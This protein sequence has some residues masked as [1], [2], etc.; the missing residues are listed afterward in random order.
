[1]QERFKDG[2]HAGN[3]I[4]T[5]L[6]QH[7]AVA[8]G[9]EGRHQ[10]AG[11]TVDQHRVD[12]DAEAETVKHRHTAQHTVAV[13]ELHANGLSGLHRA[14]VEIQIGKTDPLWG[15]AG[16]AA[17]QDHGGT[18][19]IKGDLGKRNVRGALFQERFPGFA[20]SRIRIF[21]IGSPFAEEVGRSQEGV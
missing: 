4:G 15:A 6:Y 17:V 20:L 14:G 11:R 1:M 7:S 2:G 5:L 8:F 9:I 21:Q 18:L 16:A 3:E 19:R 12:V 10:D 13:F